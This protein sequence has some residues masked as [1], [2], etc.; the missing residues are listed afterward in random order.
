[1]TTVTTGSIARAPRAVRRAV[2]RRWTRPAVRSTAISS[3]AAAVPATGRT[4]LMLAMSTTAATTMS[5]CTSERLAGS[6]AVA[7][8]AAEAGAGPAAAPPACGATPRPA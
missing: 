1:M 8:R 3:S 5:G 7:G 2:V 4:T 6:G